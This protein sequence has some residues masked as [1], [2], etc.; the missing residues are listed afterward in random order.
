[1]IKIYCEFEVHSISTDLIEIF[2]KK[3]MKKDCG[4]VKN[5]VL[6]IQMYHKIYMYYVQVIFKRH[7]IYEAIDNVDWNCSAYN[8][9][10]FNLF[11]FNVL[12]HISL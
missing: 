12:T 9:F 3:T 7:D 8:E 6:Q 10:I 1:M 4:C 11:Y 2:F 5:N